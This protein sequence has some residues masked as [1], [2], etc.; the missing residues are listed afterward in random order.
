ML[1]DTVIEELY[2]IASILKESAIQVPVWWDEGEGKEQGEAQGKIDRNLGTTLKSLPVTWRFDKAEFTLRKD[3]DK[4]RWSYAKLPGRYGDIPFTFNI[5]RSFASDGKI[6]D[7][8]YS[9]KHDAGSSKVIKGRDG[10]E[11]LFNNFFKVEGK[12]TEDSFKKVKEYLDSI[13]KDTISPLLNSY[14]EKYTKSHQRV[15]I[16]PKQGKQTI[17]IEIFTSEKDL[18]EGFDLKE[19]K[20]SFTAS[21]L[22]N[23]KKEVEEILSKIPNAPS[24]SVKPSADF[25]YDHVKKEEG[26]LLRFHLKIK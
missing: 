8:S 15:T 5:S 25:S 23:M 18:K 14:I 9:F 22:E 17:L 3:D 2:K 21:E 20:P 26:F 10:V 12:E 6:N 1:K 7:S 11:K 13:K 19:N 16:P 24:I 4:K